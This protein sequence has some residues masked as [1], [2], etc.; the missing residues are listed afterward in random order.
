MSNV[1]NMKRKAR[2]LTKTYQPAAPYVVERED[3]DDGSIHYRVMDYRPDSYRE[4]C[5]TNDWGGE[6]GHAK[7]DAEMIVRALNLLVQYG[8]E[9]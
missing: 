6:N 8:I 3:H 5:A 9:G 2:A 4:V 1:I 7:R